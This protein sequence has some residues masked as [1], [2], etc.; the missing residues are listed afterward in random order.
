MPE[1]PPIDRELEEICDMDEDAVR[2]DVERRA[3][4]NEAL[5]VLIDRY[6]VPVEWG[7]EPDWSDV[8]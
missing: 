8:L 4:R 6:P 1:K 3:L 5:D 2:A 7:D